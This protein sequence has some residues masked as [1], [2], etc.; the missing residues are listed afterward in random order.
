MRAGWLLPVLLLLPE[1][2]APHMLLSQSAAARRSLQASRCIGHIIQLHQF[3]KYSTCM[4]AYMLCAGLPIGI[5]AD[6]CSQSHHNRVLL[7]SCI[8]SCA[9]ADPCLAG[10][11]DPV[12]G[13]LSVAV[14]SWLE[15]EALVCSMHCS[16]GDF[17]T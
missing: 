16:A 5:D 9:G 7:G 14:G 13:L 1:L 4:Y 11:R 8:Y 2:E 17:D 10:Q 12:P 6:A 15:L 3:I